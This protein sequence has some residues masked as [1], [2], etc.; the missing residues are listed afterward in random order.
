MSATS[1]AMWWIPAG[2]I[3]TL[4]EAKL[5]YDHLLEHGPSEFAFGFKD[6]VAAPPE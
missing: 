1:N 3:P 5:R 2:H 6:D 4:E